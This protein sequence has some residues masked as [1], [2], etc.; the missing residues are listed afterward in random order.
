MMRLTRLQLQLGYAP[1][2]SEGNYPLLYGGG[3]IESLAQSMQYRSKIGSAVPISTIAN[4]ATSSSRLHH[5]QQQNKSIRERWRT[6]SKMKLRPSTFVMSMVMAQTQCTTAHSPSRS[7]F[8]SDCGNNSNIVSFDF[9][10]T[11]AG[12]NLE[13]AQN[14]RS[15]P[16]PSPGTLSGQSH[17]VILGS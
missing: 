9:R 16:L 11:I 7:L 15:D 13:H 6:K 1:Y 2:L 14:A 10:L 17:R 4:R 3:S 8:L 12:K 5:Q